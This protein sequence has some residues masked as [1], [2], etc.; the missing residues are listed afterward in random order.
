MDRGA[1][2]AT[3][4][5]VTENRIRLNTHTH[6]H[7]HRGSSDKS[8]TKPYTRICLLEQGRLFC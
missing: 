1:W 5:R 7:T 3:I 4:H 6:T 8:G 2:W